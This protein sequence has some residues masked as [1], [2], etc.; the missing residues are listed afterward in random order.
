MHTETDKLA[1]VARELAMRVRVYA[2]LVASGKKTQR[3]ADH[4]ISLMQAIV[5]DYNERVEKERLL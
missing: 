1:C 4:E 2:R 5:Q 3:W